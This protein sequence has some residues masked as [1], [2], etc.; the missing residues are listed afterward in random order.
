MVYF[1]I[2]KNSYLKDDLISFHNVKDKQKN[3]QRIEWNSLQQNFVNVTPISEG[4]ELCFSL[5]S[6]RF[7]Y[8]V[9]NK[10]AQYIQLGVFLCHAIPI[11]NPF[12]TNH[13]GL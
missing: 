10:R 2:T 13:R 1:F 4:C 5:E 8:F 12:T 9:L 6:S 7:V 3:S 11:A